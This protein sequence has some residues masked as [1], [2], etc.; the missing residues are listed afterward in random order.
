MNY[1]EFIT[2]YHNKKIDYDNYAGVQCV[3]LI[4]LFID[5]VI[6]VKPE[7]IGNAI[8][9]YTKFYNTYLVKYFE[10][11]DITSG[12]RKYFYYHAGDI[13]VFKSSG[14]YGHIAICTG[15]S[16]QT[17]V[18]VYDQN[19]R[20]TGE[21]MTLRELPYSLYNPLCVLRAKDTKNI[22]AF[23]FQ[24]NATVITSSDTY[25]CMSKELGAQTQSGKVFRGERVRV[26]ASGS[27][28]SI[29]QFFCYLHAS[30]KIGI[31]PNKCIKED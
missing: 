16:G 25:I 2:K 7:S 12:K 29:I 6:G 3:D 14:K 24:Q 26:L 21:G 17:F 5:K 28:N 27:K 4:K 22:N 18:E 10:R 11:I 30:Y 1:T 9:Y 15:S 20:G 8:D 31:I 19:Y 13:V 23:N